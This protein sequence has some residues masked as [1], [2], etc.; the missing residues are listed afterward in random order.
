MPIIGYSRIRNA[1]KNREYELNLDAFIL[2]VNQMVF[3]SQHQERL[4]IREDGISRRLARFN[5]ASDRSRQALSATAA[6]KVR[7]FLRKVLPGQWGDV[8]VPCAWTNQIRHQSMMRRVGTGGGIL[9]SREA[10]QAEGGEC[11]YCADRFHRSDLLGAV[12]EGRVCHECASQYHRLCGSCHQYRRSDITT[13]S[14]VSTMT[15]SERMRQ[16]RLN[17]PPV[18]AGHVF[19]PHLGRAM[20]I[21]ASHRTDQYPA[22]S[23]PADQSHLTLIQNYTTNVLGQIDGFRSQPAEEKTLPT[24]PRWLGVELE[25]EPRLI[26]D[27]DASVDYI[28]KSYLALKDFAI[29]KLDGSVLNHGFEIVTIPATLNYHREAWGPFFA[30]AAKHLQSWSTGRCGIHV[31]F[32]RNALTKTQQG[33][34]LIF[35][36]SA[37]NTAFIQEVA[38]RA[39]GTYCTRSEKNILDASKAMMMPQAD[40]ARTHHEALS[41]SSRTKGATMELRIFRGNV[42][43]RG[44]FRCLEFT[45]AMIRFCVE[46]SLRETKHEDFLRWFSQQQVRADYPELTKWLRAK[47]MITVKSNVIKPEI[48][49]EVLA[50]VA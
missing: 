40:M 17:P 10:Y 1:I 48:H 7:E 24:E 32:N 18:P 30:D 46:T 33:K 35:I 3:V 25:V 26:G 49:A 9:V 16:H 34:A 28:M 38:G 31:H 22:R 13:C 20:L 39:A 23:A 5:V 12:N 37:H 45:D 50:A 8:F 27:K 11:Y 36:N 29:L 44:F 42:S 4:D 14:C 6:R 47:G 21:A 19:V 41:Y 2:L 15:A 43:K